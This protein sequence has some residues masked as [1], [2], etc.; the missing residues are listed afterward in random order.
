[1]ARADMLSMEQGRSVIMGG[2]ADAYFELGL[3]YSTGR[4]VATDLV[5]AHKWFNLASLKGN[6]AAKAYRAEIASELSKADI[7]HAQKLAREHLQ[8]RG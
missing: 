2:S 7:A 5:T 3:K 8:K 6:Q 4:D 1:M